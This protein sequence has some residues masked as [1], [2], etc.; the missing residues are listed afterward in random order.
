MVAICPFC[1]QTL[2]YYVSCFLFF[3]LVSPLCSCGQNEQ[4][5]NLASG[6]QC[7]PSLISVSE[8]RDSASV[9]A[10]ASQK[11]GKCNTI[12]QIHKFGG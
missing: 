5:V 10:Q 2:R 9:A 7:L 1:E 12:L 11:M 4:C 8:P 6:N 3:V